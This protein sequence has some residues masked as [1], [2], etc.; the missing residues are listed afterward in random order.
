MGEGYG[1]ESS[2]RTCARVVQVV[3]GTSLGGLNADQVAVLAAERSLKCATPLPLS[4]RRRPRP[5][6]F[7]RLFGC[8]Q[9]L[10][11]PGQSRGDA[12]VASLLSR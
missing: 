4:P 5:F 1:R 10:A 12:A 3:M 6:L 9:A 11:S 8:R 2:V 7:L